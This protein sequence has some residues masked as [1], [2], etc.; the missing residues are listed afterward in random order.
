MQNQIN[1]LSL[2]SYSDTF[3][4]YQIISNFLPNKTNYSTIIPF[5]CYT[6]PPVI[7][8]TPDENETIQVYGPLYAILKELAIKAN[9]G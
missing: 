3:D 4:P 7:F 6:Y 1:L 8:G 5:I 9:A 2:K